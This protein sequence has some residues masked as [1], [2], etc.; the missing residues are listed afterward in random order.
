MEDTRQMCDMSHMCH[1][2]K[3]NCQARV[4]T[5]SM[6]CSGHVQVMYRSSQYHLHLKSQGLDLELTL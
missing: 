6:S 2:L 4:Q 5:M 1:Q 3:A